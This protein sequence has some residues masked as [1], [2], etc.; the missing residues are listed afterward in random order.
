MFSAT[1]FNFPFELHVAA[2]A[3]MASAPANTIAAIAARVMITL[4][5][6]VSLAYWMT[7]R[8]F[9]PILC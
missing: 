4:R 3:L 7:Q 8:K 9:E 5:I 1:A 2:S 6:V